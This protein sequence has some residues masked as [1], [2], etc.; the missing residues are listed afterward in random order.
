MRRHDRAHRRGRVTPAWVA[1][2]IIRRTSDMHPSS[3]DE[4]FARGMLKRTGVVART[5]R[6]VALEDLELPGHASR[7]Q[8]ANIAVRMEDRSKR[9]TQKLGTRGSGLSGA[10]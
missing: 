1:R 3:G 4:S 7:Q 8:S 10:R 2:N 9:V 5:N 6:A